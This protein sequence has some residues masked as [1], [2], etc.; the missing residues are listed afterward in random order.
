MKRQVFVAVL[1]ALLL[2]CMLA[3]CCAP[4]AQPYET[5]RENPIS[6]VPIVYQGEGELAEGF[7]RAERYLAPEQNVGEYIY[8][9]LLAEQSEIDVAAYKIS[10]DRI[11]QLYTEV[12][13]THPDLF[14]VNSGISYSYDAQDLIITLKPSYRLTGKELKA[15][16]ED[17]ANRLDKICA[18]VDP[19]WSDFE[20]ALYLHDYLCLHFEYDT[21]Y[22]IYDM[23]G[24]LTEGRGVCQAY[25][26]T[27]MELLSRFGIASGVAVSREMNHI[28][29]IVTLGGV[30][31]H[32]DV[33]WDD[34]VPNTQGLALHANFLRSDLG[35]EETKHYGWESE[36]PCT[37]DAY[38]ST[39]VTEV[40]HPFSYTAG[41]WFYATGGERAILLV[42][43]S[44]MSA[45]PVLET[46][47]K[48]MAPG[49]QSYYVDAFW[50][51]GTYRGNLIYNTPNEIYARNLQSGVVTGIEI[52]P[53]EGQQIFGLW[54]MD[55]TVYYAVSDTPDGQMQVLACSI[56]DLVDYLW[57]DADQN[58]VVDGRDVTAIR[59][60]LE[61]LPTVCHTGAADLDDSGAVDARDA[62]ILRQFLVENN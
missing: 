37:S 61:H 11:T 34:P 25:T 19:A 14:F 1:C 53:L 42:D 54:V 58:G 15:A 4:S 62:E 27:Y 43:F 13:N 33:T 24:F 41:Q 52:P 38:E 8:Q 40:E 48:W 20:I 32:V 23:Y 22:E 17:C 55:G 30:P 5:I 36:F 39:F 35:I 21:S 45:Q 46:D 59:R 12:M 47:D 29:N 28:W 7:A 51:V 10:I 44:T 60:Y 18:G 50:G 3:S 56:A 57:G 2:I 9:C 6:P 31:Y 49:G 26:L 16:R